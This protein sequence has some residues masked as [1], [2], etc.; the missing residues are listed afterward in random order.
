MKKWI[1]CTLI[2][3]SFILAGCAKSAPASEQTSSTVT[4]T[5]VPTST[6]TCDTNAAPHTLRVVIDGAVNE[7]SGCLIDQEYYFT[8]DVIQS[9]LG[10]ADTSSPV[11]IDGA[12]N[13]RLSDTAATLDLSS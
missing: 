7:V 10:F 13:Y 3:F 9:L 12:L 1:A 2:V 11:S 6:S 8:Q 4:P 5:P